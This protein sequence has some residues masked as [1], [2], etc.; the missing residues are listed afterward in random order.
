MRFVPA[1][2]ELDRW[3]VTSDIEV[4]GVAIGKIRVRR[5]ADGRV[6]LGFRDAADEQIVPDIRYV[7]ADPPVGV[8]FRSSEVIVRP[9]PTPLE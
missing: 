5:L 1:D 2:A 7:P 4:D 9:P 3:K 8:W 6:E